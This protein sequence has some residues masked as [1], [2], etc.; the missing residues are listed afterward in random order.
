VIKITFC[1]EEKAGE[2]QERNKRPRIFVIV[3]I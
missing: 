3:F 2:K 1:R